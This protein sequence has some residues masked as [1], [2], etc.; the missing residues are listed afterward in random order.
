MIGLYGI[1]RIREYNCF[2]L[3]ILLDLNCETL[4]ETKAIYVRIIKS[5]DQQRTIN[6]FEQTF[7]P[8]IQ[9]FRYDSINNNNNN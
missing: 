7:V 9:S 8:L 1:L 3:C 5:N 2:D 6:T 4:N